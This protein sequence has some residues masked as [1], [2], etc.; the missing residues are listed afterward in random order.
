MSYDSKQMMKKISI[1]APCYNEV[2]NIEIFYEKLKKIFEDHLKNYIYEIIIVDDCSKDG[3]IEVLKKLSLIDKNLKVILNNR[4][5]GVFQST[6]NAIKYATGDSLIPMM[7]VDMQDTPE[8]MVDFVRNWE[9]GFDVV[10]GIK[11]KEMKI[12]F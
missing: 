4:N 8:V 3:S 2:D 9:Q 1:I 5:Y 7:P 12:L 6:F 11:K 10:Y